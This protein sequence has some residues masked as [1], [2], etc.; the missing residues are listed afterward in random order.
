MK[1]LS[2]L[3]GA[4]SRITFPQFSCDRVS[5]VANAILSR[6]TALFSCF[7]F[8]SRPSV[9]AEVAAPPAAEPA[10]PPP[11]AAEPASP[12]PAAPAPAPETPLARCLNLILAKVPKQGCR[13][14]EVTISETPVKASLF[15]H[16]KETEQSGTVQYSSFNNFADLQVNEARA[17]EL[18]ALLEEKGFV[19]PANSLTGTRTVS[20]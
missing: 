15:I 7:W 1:I 2:C 19:F 5:R 9:V 16:A 10:S 17:T 3:L 13:F 6:L 20:N 14:T 18:K 4:C 12:P 8:F 11:A